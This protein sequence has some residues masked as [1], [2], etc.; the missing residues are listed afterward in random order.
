[1]PAGDKYTL[2]RI[3]AVSETHFADDLERFDGPILIV[4]GDDDRIAPSLCSSRHRS[5][6]SVDGMGC[7]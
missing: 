2:D 7:R 6:G 5:S 1:M 3:K 4:S